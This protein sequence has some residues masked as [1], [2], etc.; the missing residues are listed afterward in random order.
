MKDS[1]EGLTED[2]SE[3]LGR[4]QKLQ[5]EL[6][7]V[8]FERYDRINPFFENVTDWRDKGKRY[9]NE[10]VV[11]FDS[12]TIMG[13][14]TMGKHCWIGPHC[15]IDG[16]GGLE[17]GDYCVFAA[18]THVYTHDTVKWALSGG[19]KPYKH[20][21][22][23]IGDRVFIGAQ[24]VILAGVTVGKC[25]LI[26]ANATVTSDIAPYSIAAGT[27]AKTIGHVIIE[28]ED[29]RFEYFNEM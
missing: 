24:S 1:S 10:D 3:L 28:G 7:A 22:V 17:V 26:C 18:G 23:T 12:A 13:N 19:K 11:A 16:S 8:T 2:S 21:P 9:L 15:L 14:V 25:T 20:A 29:V 27:P 5:A 6:D 4:L